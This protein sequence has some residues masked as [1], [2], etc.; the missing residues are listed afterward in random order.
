MVSVAHTDNRKYVKRGRDLVIRHDPTWE[1][2]LREINC[3]KESVHRF[4]MQMHDHAVCI[5]KNRASD[6]IQAAIQ[7]Y[8]GN[9]TR[10]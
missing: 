5:N 3:F 2:E 10:S 9:A 7:N 4:Y 1:D 6:A 8:Q